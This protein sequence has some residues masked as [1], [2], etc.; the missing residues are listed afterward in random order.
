M[1]PE[2]FVPLPNPQYG[3]QDAA[4]EVWD[5]ALSNETERYAIQ[6]LQVINQA[7]PCMP[8]RQ[9]AGRILVQRIVG[10]SSPL[11]TQPSVGGALSAQYWVGEYFCQVCRQG[12]YLRFPHGA[13]GPFEVL[14][15]RRFDV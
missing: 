6:W 7:I 11:L 3:P 12:F 1:R 5:W 9:T 13:P 2:Q 15:G 8:Q 10:G 4:W 14:A